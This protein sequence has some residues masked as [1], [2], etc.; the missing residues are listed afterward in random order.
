LGTE[1][2]IKR[3]VPQENNG[4]DMKKI[5]IRGLLAVGFP[6]PPPPPPRNMRKTY[7][8]IIVIIAISTVALGV[9]LASNSNSPNPIVTPT[10]SQSSNVS[11]FTTPPPT[12]IFSSS[13]VPSATA[14]DGGNSTGSFVKYKTASYVDTMGVGT[15]A[16]SILIPTDWQFEGNINW[17]LDNPVMPATANIRVWNPSGTEEF[18]VFP[19]QALF[20]TDNPLIQQTN[21]PGS[22]YF[23]A[24]VMQPVGPI[25]ALRETILPM[26]RSNVDNLKIVSEQEL[27]ELNQLFNTGTDPT[28]GTSSSAN[29]GKIRVEY[30]L[31]GVLMEDELYCVI[32]SVKIPTQSIYG[33][34]TND[35]WYM[36]YLASFRAEKGKL[37]S[38]SKI[39][40]T[41]ALSSK[42]DKDW[43]NKYNQLVYYLIQNQIRQ[44]QS[45]GQLSNMLSQMSDQ[46]SDQNLKDWEQKQ[47]VNDGLVENFCNQIL[48][49]QPYNNPIDGTT[50]DL[51]SGYSSVW[52]NSL[53]EYILGESS[54][55]NPNIGSNLNW[56]PMTVTNG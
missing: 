28:T 25:E 55:F 5:L 9:Y 3:F 26:F 36:S 42:T 8:A 14:T 44:I 20:W 34:T 19:N 37:D 7:S 1:K 41:I 10:P 4:S 47:S 16:F 45:I 27:P 49:V 13:P 56:Q 35:N 6:P 15:T 12:S 43:L 38:E 2:L 30:S 33:T 32:Q 29:G 54:S 24:L 46:I 53:G 40:Q 52:T 18:D 31:N 11:P 21:P 22:T 17:I 51:P 39:F 50:V 48:E 23:G